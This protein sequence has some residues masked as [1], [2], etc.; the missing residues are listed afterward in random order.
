MAISGTGNS[1]MDLLCTPA[2]VEELMEEQEK[3]EVKK[4][5]ARKMAATAYEENIS[6]FS[7]SVVERQKNMMRRRF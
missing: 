6:T 3:E 2:Q 5:K 1:S 7:K 4:A